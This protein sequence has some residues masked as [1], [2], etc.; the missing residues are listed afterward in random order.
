MDGP[1]SMPLHVLAVLND[2]YYF[3]FAV[4]PIIL[5]FCGGVMEDDTK[6]VVLRY[7]SYA[8]YF[9]AKWRTLVLLSFELWL[10]QMM[11][12]AVSGWGYSL[13][14]G[15]PDLSGAEMRREIFALLETVFPHPGIALLCAALHLLAGYWLIAL[16]TLWL[17]H[18]APQSRAVQTL[19]ALYVLAVFQ[20]K[21]PVMSRP[22]LAYLTGLSHWVLLLH[23]LTE[24]WRFALTA[25]VT[26]LFLAGVAYTVKKCWCRQLFVSRRTAKGLFP[27]YSRILFAKNHLLLAA[28]LIFL[29][30][31]WSWFRGGVPENGRKW[32]IQLLAGHGTGEFYPMGLLSLLLAEVLPLW[33]IGSLVSHAVSQR[34]IY[35]S[36]RLRQRREILSALLRITLAWLAFW[37]VLVLAAETLPVLI[38][39]L[40]IDW[41]LVIWASGLRLL[42]MELQ[43]LLLFA[44]LC[45]TGQTA[46]GFLGI[47][48]LHFLC[49][50]PL[51]WFPIGLSSLLRLNLPE[52]GGTVS[53][54]FAAVGLA[55][56][57]AI[58][59]A[60]LYIQ[61]TERLF[62][63]SGG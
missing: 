53:P 1:P 25:T 36:M 13:T 4:L 63:K 47:V 58:L 16:L 41:P 17:G 28:L 43:S 40:Q 46:I 14:S 35:L 34:S 52:T 8:K 31:E 27:Y 30:S 49:V 29:L 45:C 59:L 37:N 19:I 26:F 51:P 39:D 21:L 2:Q 5:F 22:P 10:G 6:I 9:A 56:G 23:N 15:W 33:P 18:F 54:V 32:V 50:L 61:G 42:D 60:W 7:G 3:V 20:L 62:E 12:L 48:L 24:P 44:I 57:C 38:L 11:I 55:I